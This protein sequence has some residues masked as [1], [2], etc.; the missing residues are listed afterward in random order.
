MKEY[1]QK[2]RALIFC[3]QED[4]GII[5]VEAQA[6]GRPVIAYGKGG[7]L[8]TVINKETG[9][10]FE[11]QETSSVIE[12]IKNFEEMD[13]RGCFDSKNIEKHAGKFSAENFR[14][15]LQT[16]IQKI[17]SKKSL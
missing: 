4:F 6:S 8:E 1:L 13:A 5:P 17:L 16:E 12:A 15:N 7:A 14:K 2:C 9:V 3:A 10:F 11:E